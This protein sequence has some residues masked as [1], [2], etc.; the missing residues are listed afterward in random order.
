MGTVKMHPILADYKK[1][2]PGTVNAILET[3]NGNREM[4]IQSMN[5]L[6][7][8]VGREKPNLPRESSRSYGAGVGLNELKPAAEIGIALGIEALENIVYV[9]VREDK[10]L[11]IATATDIL[12]R[13]QTIYG[14]K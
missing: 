2:Y 12:G 13:L 8:V 5:V 7:D 4:A 14:G 11:S 1:N 3:Y 9:A 10:P 6:F